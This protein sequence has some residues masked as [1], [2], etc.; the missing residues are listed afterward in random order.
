MVKVDLKGSYGRL[1][2][3]VGTDYKFSALEK[4]GVQRMPVGVGFLCDKYDKSRHLSYPSHMKACLDEFSAVNVVEMKSNGLYAVTQFGKTVLDVVKRIPV[5]REMSY[6]GTGNRM[7]NEERILLS[8]LYNGQIT[9]PKISETTGVSGKTLTESLRKLEKN[10]LVWKPSLGVKYVR[11]LRR[12]R[13]DELNGS[14]STV[15]ERYAEMGREEVML[16]EI[17]ERVPTGALSYGKSGLIRKGII[18]ERH[19]ALKFG[20]T[21]A[22]KI[23]ANGIDKIN[24]GLR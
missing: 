24:S 9:K 17:A 3:L 11:G 13:N 8:L 7:Y 5:V 18:S 20:L 12:P 10:L 15:Y 23:T 6:S 1:M 4:L 19:V 14:E 2:N 22:G 21:A 16:S